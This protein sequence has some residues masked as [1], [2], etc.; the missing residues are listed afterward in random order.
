MA[1]ETQVARPLTLHFNLVNLAA[2][3]NSFPL[4]GMQLGLC[5]VS[6]RDADLKMNQ[7][8]DSGDFRSRVTFYAHMC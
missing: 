5:P 8:K 6:M 3:V 7:V 2:A 4:N 1:N